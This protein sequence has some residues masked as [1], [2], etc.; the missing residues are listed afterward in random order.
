MIAFLKQEHD[1]L[2]QQ[3]QIVR[4]EDAWHDGLADMVPN[5]NT[6]VVP[7]VRIAGEC[8]SVTVQHSA[9]RDS[10]VRYSTVQ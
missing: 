9:V 3:L 8:L 2:K 4:A 7:Q 1:D 5:A 6:R 10:T